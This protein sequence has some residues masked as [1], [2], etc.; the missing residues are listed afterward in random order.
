[1]KVIETFSGKNNVIYFI[2]NEKFDSKWLFL[3]GD[4]GGVSVEEFEKM[5]EEAENSLTISYDEF[6]KEIEEWLKG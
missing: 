4:G 1:M 5:V 6:L 3:K 2:M